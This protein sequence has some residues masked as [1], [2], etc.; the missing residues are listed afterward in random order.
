MK[1]GEKMKNTGENYLKF[2]KKPSEN[3]WKNQKKMSLNR[4]FKNQWLSFDGLPLWA[5]NNTRPYKPHLEGQK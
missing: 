5:T 4:V 2:R 1:T 3:L